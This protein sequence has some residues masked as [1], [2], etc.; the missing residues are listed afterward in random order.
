MSVPPPAWNGRKR[1]V[2]LAPP[3]HSV[4]LGESGA[5]FR[6]G[7]ALEYS[8]AVHCWDGRRRNFVRQVP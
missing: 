1:R 3:V 6:P 8:P 5:G 7:G 4:P 2:P